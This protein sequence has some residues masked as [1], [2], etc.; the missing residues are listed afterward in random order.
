M[1]AAVFQGESDSSQK[2]KAFVKATS[3]KRR[4]MESIEEFVRSAAFICKG[5]GRY[6][7]VGKWRNERSRKKETTRKANR[8][9]S[10][11]G[12]G[13][14]VKRQHE[15]DVKRGKTSSAGSGALIWVP[16]SRL[17]GKRST[18]RR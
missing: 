11:R 9:S 5:R 16:A 13:Q 3:G 8:K 18:P 17:R 1:C 14:V 10:G 6:L 2:K 15:R 4:K 12:E 7:G